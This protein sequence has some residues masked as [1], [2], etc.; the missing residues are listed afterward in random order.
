[1]I[2]TNL[3]TRPFYNVRAVQMAIAALVVLVLAI[4]AWNVT[5]FVRLTATQNTL[6]AQAQT[7][8]QDAARLRADAARIRAGIDASELEV[9]AAAA[10]EANG[11]IDQRAFSWTTLFGQFES[12][13]PADVRI[14][15]VT[16]RPRENLVGI[17]VEARS[18]EDLSAFIEAL[19]ATGRFRNVLATDEVGM[20]GDLIGATLQATYEPAERRQAVTP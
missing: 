17:G 15:F 11:I 10:R 12:T 6:G 9:V 20:E 16:P 2:R 7:A 4:T 18:V 13:L 3:S 5:Q 19:E 8:E 1:M 14:T